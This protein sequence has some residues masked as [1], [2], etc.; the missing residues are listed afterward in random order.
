[1][2]QIA[3]GLQLAPDTPN[4]KKSS[5]KNLQFLKRKKKLRV[6]TT[7]LDFG[8]LKWKYCGIKNLVLVDLCGDSSWGK[9]SNEKDFLLNFTTTNYR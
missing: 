8:Q 6:K 9:T 1:M 2:L 7:A 5:F 3:L 4:T